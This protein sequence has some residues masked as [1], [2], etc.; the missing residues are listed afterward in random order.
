[1]TDLKTAPQGAPTNQTRWRGPA[2][3]AAVAAV[4]LVVVGIVGLM[5]RSDVAP[6]DTPPTTVPAPEVEAPSD[7]AG[8]VDAYLAA[9]DSGDYE[10]YEAFLDPDKPD[11]FVGLN[12]GR[13]SARYQAATGMI[14]THSCS[15][16][17]STV[18]C[19]TTRRSGLDPAATYPP[20]QMVA[21]VENGLITELTFDAT[22][23][24][25]DRADARALE[26]YRAWVQENR[27]DVYDQLFGSGFEI[28]LSPP[29]TISLHREVVAEYLGA[30]G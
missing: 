15:A 17:G 23:V 16:D 7:P 18:T 2:I 25:A 24:W 5:M 1:M 19:T 12:G 28:L 3:A 14:A 20:Y 13:T 8:V 30:G 21:T 10:A 6:A 27:A 26:G 29:D 22:Y 4:I 11:L 9:V